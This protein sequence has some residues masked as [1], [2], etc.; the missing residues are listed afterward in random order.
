VFSIGRVFLVKGGCLYFRGVGSVY[1]RVVV[2]SSGWLCL[3]YGGWV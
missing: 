3:V 1:I 2:F